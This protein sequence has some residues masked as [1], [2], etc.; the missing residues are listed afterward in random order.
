MPNHFRHVPAAKIKPTQR[1]LQQPHLGDAGEQVGDVRGDRAHHRQ[2]LALAQV[3][4]QAQFL[5]ALLLHDGEVQLC[6]L[7]VAR[8]LACI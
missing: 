2:R 8:E 7:E 4:V 1:A 3:A 5:H 6:V